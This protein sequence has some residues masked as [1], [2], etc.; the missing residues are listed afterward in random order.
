MFKTKKGVRYLTLGIIV[1]VLVTNIGLGSYLS[2]KDQAKNS[3]NTNNVVPTKEQV[4]STK[5]SFTYNGVEGKN[6]LEIL[7]SKTTVE[8]NNSG[9]VVSINGRKADDTKREFWAFYVNGKMAE[10][11]PAEY[12]T[13]DG[14][15]IEWK[16]ETY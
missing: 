10:V 13:N 9:L 14:D 3:N 12:V 6:A 8:Q 4:K 2:S 5:D 7:E 16:I 11:G 1:L 15:Q